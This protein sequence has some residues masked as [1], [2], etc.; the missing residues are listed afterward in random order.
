MRTAFRVLIGSI[1]FRHPSEEILKSYSR[2]EVSGWA[3][4]VIREHLLDC[5]RCILIAGEAS[6]GSISD[7]LLADDFDLV[8][9]NLLQAIA[10][11]PANRHSIES[12]RIILGERAAEKVSYGRVSPQMRI[13]FEALLGTGAAESLIRS[14]SAG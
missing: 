1:F 2:Q 13:E 6:E 4:R 11:Q 8:R 10:S 14:L 12:L 3:G 5:E 7:D 9:A